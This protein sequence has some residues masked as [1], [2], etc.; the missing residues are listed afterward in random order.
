MSKRSISHFFASPPVK[1]VKADSVAIEKPLKQSVFYKS[2]PSYPIPLPD[3][4]PFAL[5]CNSSFKKIENLPS[6]SLY[7]YAPLFPAH[8]ATELFNFLL[9]NMPWYRVTYEVRGITINTPRYT[10]VFGLDETHQFENGDGPVLE[11]ATGKPPKKPLR[12]TPRPIPGALLQLK[13]LIE[14]ETGESF[15]FCLLNYYKDGQDSISYHSDDEHFLGPLPSIASLSLGSSR[16]FL[17]RLKSDHSIKWKTSLKS[18]DCILMR[19]ETQSKWDHSIPKRASAAGRMNLTFRKAR[20]RYGTENYYNYNVHSGPYYRWHKG[21]MILGSEFEALAALP[22]P[23]TDDISR[24]PD[25]ISTIE[26]EES[27]D[28]AAHVAAI[29]EAVAVVAKNK[30]D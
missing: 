15:N 20:V 23:A 21:Q 18:G 27:F 26:K 8:T 25:T 17:M 4:L 6:L 10:T 7:Y 1:K 29:D 2:H 5:E 3:A 11:I 12:C 19:Q 13:S 9:Q 22:G 16:D 30:A 14:R 28:V 24:L